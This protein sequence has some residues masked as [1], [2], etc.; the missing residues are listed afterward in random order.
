MGEGAAAE[1]TTARRSARGRS[2]IVGFDIGTQALKA[3]V[4][5][6]ELALLGRASVP[7]EVSYPSPGWAEQDPRDWERALKP[8]LAAALAEAGAETRQIAAVGITGQLDGC[9]AVDAEGR[10]L[11]PCLIWIDRRARLGLDRETQV[12]LRQVSGINPDPSHLAAKACWLREHTVVGPKVI[13]FHQPVSYLVLRLTGWHVM[14]HCLASTTMLYSLARRGY[15]HRLLAAFG[16]AAS[17]LPEIGE[18]DSVAGPVSP[19]GA[20]LSGIPEG[21]PVAVGTG[22]DFASPLGAGMTEPGTAACVLGTAEVA[23]AISEEPR[24][25]PRGLVET[26]PFPGGGY[27]VENP[28]W[29]AGGAVTW[30]QQVFRLGDVE[31][32]TRLAAA[33]PVGAEGLL[34]LPALNGAMAPEWVPTARGCF[35]GMTPGHGTGHF[36]RALLEGCAYAMRD[37]TTRLGELG[38]PVEAILLMGG[39]SASLLWAAIRAAV[40][41]RPVYRVRMADTAPVGAAMLAAVAAGLQPDL[42]ACAARVRSWIGPVTGEPGDRERYEA[43]YAAYRRLFESLRPMY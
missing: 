13:R 33:S 42:Q 11:S 22:D 37:V 43:G 28:G 6:R 20:E 5:D 29:L 8:A 31:A 3:L 1:R 34:F 17:E 15:D 35:Y 4:L 19:G 25:D 7:L 27:Y 12:L 21:V 38:V 14:D 9:I 39:G 26:H 10:G 32:L 2:L 41:G 40:S 24:V 30:F 36:A 18:A 23:G 16:L